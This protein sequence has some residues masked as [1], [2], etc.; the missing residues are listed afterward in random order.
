MVWAASDDE[1]V[2]AVPQHGMF[3][4]PDNTA[5]VRLFYFAGPFKFPRV[6]SLRLSDGSRWAVATGWDF[7]VSHISHLA[8][9]LFKKSVVVVVCDC[10]VNLALGAICRDHVAYAAFTRLG[11]DAS[12]GNAWLIS[13]LSVGLAGRG[14]CATG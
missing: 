2:S 12:Q 11:K 4:G 3:G 14:F 10:C 1:P 13:P 9:T 8:E 6:R 5:G 7:Y